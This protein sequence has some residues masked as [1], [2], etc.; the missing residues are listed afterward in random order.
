MAVKYYLINCEN[1]NPSTILGDKEYIHVKAHTNGQQVAI[2]SQ[3]EL[4]GENIIEKTKE[5]LQTIL[6][7]WINEENENP[8]TRILIDGTIEDIL[9]TKIDLNI[10]GVNNG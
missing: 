7:N 8:E 9:Q 2:I 3:E 6:D 10:Y 5:E 1:R 4:S